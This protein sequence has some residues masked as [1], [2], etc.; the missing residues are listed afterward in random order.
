MTEEWISNVPARS[1]AT[2]FAQVIEQPP[3][4]ELLDNALS[5]KE[6]LDAESR[7]RVRRG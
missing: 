1:V 4:R 5:I 2:D 6:R 7:D 3:L